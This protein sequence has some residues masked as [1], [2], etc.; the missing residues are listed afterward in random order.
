MA[1]PNLWG[2]SYANVVAT[3]RSGNTLYVGG[4]FSQ[5]GPNTGSG[6]PLQYGVGHAASKYAQVNGEI[7][8]AITDGE[9]GWFI[10]GNFTAVGGQSRLHLAHIFANGEVAEWAPDPNKQVHALGLSGETLY[11]GGQF[12]TIA[13]QPRGLIA[14]VDI[15]TGQAT[16]W[17]PGATGNLYGYPAV[18]AL[19]LRGDTIYIGG[20]FLSIGGLSRHYLAALH[21]LTGQALAWNPNPDQPV[22]VITL[23]GSVAYVGGPFWYVGGQRRYLAGAV[24]LTTGAATNWDPHI[25]DRRRQYYEPVPEVMALMVREGTVFIAGFWDSLG[26]QFRSGLGAVDAATGALKT[27]DPRPAGGFPY[28]YVRAL[29][30]RGDTIYVGG[31][32]STMQAAPRICLAGVD[33]TTAIPT[34]WDPRPNDEVNALVVDDDFIY[35]AG[36]Y[37]TLGPWQVRYNL[38]A[39]DLTT[40]LPTDWN[41]DP[42]GLIVY[43]LEVKDGIVYAGGD[44]TYVGAQARSGIAALDAVSGAATG[45]NP[46]ANGAVGSMVLRGDTVYVGGGFTRIGG[47]PRSYVAALD[48]ATGLATSWDPHAG[49]GSTVDAMILQGNTIYLGGSFATMG[50]ERRGALAAVDATTG[51]LTPWKADLTTGWINSMV[52]SGGKLYVAGMFDT[53]AGEPR[54]SLAALDPITGAVAAWNPTPVRAPDASY[55]PPRMY[56]IAALDH[57][58]F[59]GGEF[60]RVGGAPRVGLAAVD[61]SIGR[62]TDW[63]PHADGIVWSLLT[64]GS[65]LYVGGKFRTIGELPTARL[66]EIT[67]PPPPTPPA[68][69][70]LALAQSAP[71]PARTTAIIHFALP[72]AGPVTL[73]VF[74]V[75]G[76]R[77]A[78]LLDRQVHTAGGHDVLVRAD[79]WGSGAYFYR[80]EAAGRSATRKMIVVE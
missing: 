54:T 63:N 2:L 59:V 39:L 6:I 64:N 14:A 9:G 62:A 58:I 77:V 42:D 21:A 80:L 34:A 52:I 57:Q 29:A 25:T 28:S 18:S 56:A 45:W 74:D 7:L 71:N 47:Q 35:A 33:A 60:S 55:G 20:N 44:F 61:D 65:T 48:A 40:G 19:A 11:V 69:A 15:P 46:S 37:C 43:S 75:Q 31:Y 24:D 30:A 12:D 10:G 79:Q 49:Y 17:N 66:A 50:P 51:A 16:S 27:W 5:V 23:H 4:A 32:F 22:N 67:F 70:A 13:G 41:P 53:I 78:T 72:A 1:N 3:V 76:R 68:P 26:G 38:A 73:E 36:N 8:A